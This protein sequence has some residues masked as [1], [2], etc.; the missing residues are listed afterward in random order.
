MTVA[1]SF[2]NDEGRYQRQYIKTGGQP[3]M[4]MLEIKELDK[5]LIQ[6]ANSNS[7]GGTRGDG[8]EHDYH[9]YANR[10]LS[11]EISDEKKRKLLDKLYEKWMVMLRHEAQH[12]S[13]MVAGASKYNS[14]RLD[15]SDKILSLSAEFCE[16]FGDL[17]RQVEAGKFK[18]DKAQELIRLVE[19]AKRQNA[20][21]VLTAY[22]TEL[23]FYD[24][25][26]FKKYYEELSPTYKW[27]K[28]STI[29]KV[30]TEAQA[31][32]LKV[33]KKEI[34]F[35]D[36]NLTAYTEGDRAYIRFT[37]RPKRQL[38]LALKS[39]GYWWNNRKNAW[40]TYLDRLDEE[41]VRGISTQY[42]KY[43]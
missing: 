36:G 2:D 19:S 13:V 24:P 14:K 34:F 6:R 27:R 1:K 11:W 21:E 35:E 7:F 33:I 28:N 30:Y 22:L 32:T 20:R 15:H 39:R 12:V 10:I 18:D 31:G 25:E 5:G 29:A 38:I 26:T 3:N 16:W 43:I 4:N 37:M 23:A 17:E 41:W 42:A 8:S 40:S 9:V